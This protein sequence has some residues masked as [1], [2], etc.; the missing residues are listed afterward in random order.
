L[1]IAEEEVKEVKKRDKAGKSARAE[2]E[3]GER[4]IREGG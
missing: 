4:G 1:R 3:M 2:S